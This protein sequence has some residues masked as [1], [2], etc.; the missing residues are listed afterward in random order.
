MADFSKKTFTNISTI[1][2]VL[3]QW[4][5]TLTSRHYSQCSQCTDRITGSV[6]ATHYASYA[7]S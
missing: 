7:I 1:F 6:Y 5:M 2:I 4:K 3:K